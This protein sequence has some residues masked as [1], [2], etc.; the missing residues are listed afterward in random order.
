MPGQLRILVEGI[1]ERG[2]SVVRKRVV[3]QAGRSRHGT[4]GKG[5][6]VRIE[7]Q[8]AELGPQQRP[9]RLIAPDSDVCAFAH[10]DADFWPAPD[11]VIGVLQE[12]VEELTLLFDAFGMVVVRPFLLPMHLKPLPRRGHALV[13]L[14]RAAGVQAM[15]GP[16]GNDEG[17][18]FNC[19]KIDFLA[20]PVS[21]VQRMLLHVRFGIFDFSG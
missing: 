18:R 17:G 21:V 6:L 7:K 20:L 19:R 1:V 8:L 9:F 5:A 11:S 2:P 13:G 15:V 16:G 12:V 14:Q 4:F 10:F 3:A